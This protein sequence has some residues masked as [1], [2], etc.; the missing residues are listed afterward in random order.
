MQV[1]NL[2]VE[3]ADLPINEYRASG[4][5]LEFRVLDPDGHLYP[6]WRSKWK[7]LTPSDIDAA[8]QV[9]HGCGPMV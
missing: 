1:T 6:D 5:Y 9:Q 3:V 7:R 4:G 2:R 8:L